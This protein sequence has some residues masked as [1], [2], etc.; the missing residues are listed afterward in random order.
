MK[1]PR[2]TIDL[3]K[4]KHNLVR[5][6]KHLEA[7]DLDM[8]VVS[9]VFRA[10]PRLMKVINDVKVPYVADSRIENL[11]GMQT[12][13]EKVLLRLPSIHELSEVVRHADIS[14]NSELA[15]IHGL[16]EASKNQ[17]VVHKVIFM[18]DIGD[19]REGAYHTEP[20]SDY[21]KEI[22]S[23]S[24]IKLYGIGTNV[25]C[26]GGVLPTKSTIQ[27]LDKVVRSVQSVIGRPL[28]MISGGNSSQLAFLD[29]A[30]KG[31]MTNLRIGEALALGRETSYGTTLEGFYDDVF[32]LEADIVEAKVKPSY[33]EGE[34]G[35]DAFG[36]KP[37]FKDKGTRK[38]AILAIGKQDVDHNELMPFDES[39]T[40]IGSSSDHIIADITD[41]MTD[42]TVGD[43]LRFKLKYGSLLSLMTSPYVVKAYV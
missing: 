33:P 13:A 27:K 29:A 42:Y 16:N 15:T 20:I 25:T 5:M 38:R 41:S 14:L 7:N 8:M 18:V 35:M 22:E 4:Y 1:Y 36:K 21:A 37:V 32:V 39:V 23:L 3:K 34:T 2:M 24:H 26:H 19:L 12:D 17:G 11:Q 28:K 6:K 31:T 30:P 43:T 10:D 9:K 40:L